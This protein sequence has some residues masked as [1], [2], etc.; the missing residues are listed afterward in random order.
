MPLYLTSAPSGMLSMSSAVDSGICVRATS[1]NLLTKGWFGGMVEPC[2]A[3]SPAS[4]F[5]GLMH[6]KQPAAFKP[7]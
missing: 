3:P 7:V 6:A 1:L 4:L 2:S 5:P